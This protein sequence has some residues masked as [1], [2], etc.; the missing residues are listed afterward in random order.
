MS[1]SSVTGA[2]LSQRPTVF[3]IWLSGRFSTFPTRPVEARAR[4]RCRR[5]LLADDRR[6][7][8]RVDVREHATL[9]IDDLPARCR[10]RD[11]ARDV[12]VGERDVAVTG[13]D[14]QVPEPEG[15]DSEQDERQYAEQLDA[16]A[17]HRRQ[18]RASL[19]WAFDHARESGLRLPEVE[20]VAWGRRS[21]AGRAPSSALRVSA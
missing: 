12:R 5:Q 20:A 7:R 19:D 16:P 14:L 1:A 4:G 11:V 21:L 9:A 18:G 15:D 17:E 6:D 3:A 2:K 13:Q 10:D 8:G